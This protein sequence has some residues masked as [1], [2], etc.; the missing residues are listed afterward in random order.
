LPIDTA[1]PEYILRAESKTKPKPRKN[2]MTT[3]KV[4][5]EFGRFGGREV[6]EIVLVRGHSAEIRKLW[7][8][9]DDADAP[10]QDRI[11]RRLE[12]IG[13]VRSAK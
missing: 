1:D 9:L 8:A 5:G 2:E 13:A 10:E 7:R 4:L 11:F 12:A 6:V 3:T